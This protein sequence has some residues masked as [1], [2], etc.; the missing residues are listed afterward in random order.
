MTQPAPTPDPAPAHVIA[1]D[2]GMTMRLTTEGHALLVQATTL[3][4]G[5]ILE[6]LSDLQARELRDYLCRTLGQPGHDL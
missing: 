6:R 2:H 5:V 1:F 3:H 4:S